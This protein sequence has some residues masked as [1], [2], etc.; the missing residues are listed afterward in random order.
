VELDSKCNLRRRDVVKM[1]RDYD[2]YI[3]FY[4]D[5]PVRRNLNVYPIARR[6]DSL[7]ESI[8]ITVDMTTYDG[9]S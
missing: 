4:H 7:S 3:G 2:S 6:T 9:V 1:K 8:H 5:L